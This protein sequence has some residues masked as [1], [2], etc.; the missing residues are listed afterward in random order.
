M[1][2]STVDQGDY[3]RGKMRDGPG[4]LCYRLTVSQ[5]T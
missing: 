3:E 5:E 2:N 4:E 1:Q